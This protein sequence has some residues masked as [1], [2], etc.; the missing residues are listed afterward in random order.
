MKNQNKK[1]KIVDCFLFYDEIEML[2]FRLIELQDY[3]DYFVI[4]ESDTDFKNKEKE[5]IF[6]KKKIFFQ[7]WSDKIIHIPI[8]KKNK[9]EILDKK[10]QIELFSKL[11][12]DKFSE[13]GLW[14]EDIIYFSDIDEFPPLNTLSEYERYLAFEPVAF[15]QKNFLW[16]TKYYN[17]NPHLGTFCFTYSNF[18]LDPTLITRIYSEKNEI[19]SSEYKIFP[20]GFHFSHF[21]SIDKIVNKMNLIYDEVFTEYDI[22]YLQ[23]T[24]QPNKNSN[25]FLLD[26]EGDLPNGLNNVPKIDLIKR[27]N[28]KMIVVFNFLRNLIN[29]ELFKDYSKIININF[30]KVYEN[31]N[32]DT[33]SEK[34][35]NFNIFVPKKEYY[36]SQKFDLEFG[37][38]EI[39]AILKNYYPLND[40]EFHFCKFDS[41]IDL[42]NKK[43]YKW[44]EIKNELLFDLLSEYFL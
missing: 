18:L 20:G 27:D 32:E 17:P 7:E 41:K 25:S 22:V 4:L 28:K 8:I 35:T 42:E 29:E 16:N 19:F 12:V 38:N 10:I 26:Y 40:D 1:N 34:T 5:L 15:L 3:V 14:F 44:S 31:E 23:S 21:Y 39:K 37:I 2:K 43:I 36:E 33:V 30:L 24:L 13:L 6:E 9:S 11:M